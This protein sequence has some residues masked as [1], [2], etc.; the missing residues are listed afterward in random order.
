MGDIPKERVRIR[1]KVFRNAG[2]D[3]FGLYHIKMNKK[4]KSNSDT[5]KR[6]GVMFTCLVTRAVYIKLAKDLS[7]DAFMLTL[8]RFI[9]RRGSVQVIQSDTDTNFVGANKELKSC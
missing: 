5:A 8:H 9:S 4:T 6:Y 2:I 1:D 3:Y 7:T